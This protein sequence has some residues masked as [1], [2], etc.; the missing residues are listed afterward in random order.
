MQPN[1]I[2]SKTNSLILKGLGILLMLFHHLF[3]SSQVLLCFGII[4]YM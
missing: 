3:Y 4:I 2:I 1:N